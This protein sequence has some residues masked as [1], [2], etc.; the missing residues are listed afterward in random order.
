MITIFAFL[1]NLLQINVMV[2]NAKTFSEN[3]LN[4][5]TLIPAQPK[6]G[7]TMPPTHR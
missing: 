5:V 7:T 4:I 6:A 1:T 3:I 2:K